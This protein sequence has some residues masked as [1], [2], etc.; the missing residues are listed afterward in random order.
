MTR[1]RNPQAEQMGDESM[2]RNLAYQ[3]DAFLANT[4]RILAR[5]FWTSY[6][7]EQFQEAARWWSRSTQMGRSQ[8]NT[9]TR[10]TIPARRNEEPEH[11]KV[12]H[13]A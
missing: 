6:D 4:D 5:L 8:S 2:V 3:A 13:R 10:Q 1:D 11:A 7:T 9:P 12:H